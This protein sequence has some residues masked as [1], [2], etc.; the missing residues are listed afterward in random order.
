[1]IESNRLKSNHGLPLKISPTFDATRQIRYSGS[2]TQRARDLHL[3]YGNPYSDSITTNATEKLEMRI[4]KPK[5]LLHIKFKASHN[6]QQSYIPQVTFAQTRTN[7]FQR[8]PY[9]NMTS[10][11]FFSPPTSRLEPK[12]KPIPQAGEKYMQNRKIMFATQRCFPFLN[13]NDRPKNLHPIAPKIPLIVL[14]KN[15]GLTRPN[16]GRVL[17]PAMD[18]NQEENIQQKQAP[19]LTNPILY[20]GTAYKMKRGPLYQSSVLVPAKKPMTVPE[21]RPESRYNKASLFTTLE[22]GR[23]SSPDYKVP[24]LSMNLGESKEQQVLLPGCWN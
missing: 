2:A 4:A 5:E 14:S 23:S 12:F 7:N 11:H 21:K 19:I 13:G 15:K 6:H 3:I 18:K 22:N 16:T 9:C 8:I 10:Q 17:C 24:I 20:P 1:M